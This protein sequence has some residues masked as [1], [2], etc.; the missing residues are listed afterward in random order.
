MPGLNIET[1]VTGA[2]G[3]KGKLTNDELNHIVEVIDSA[4]GDNEGV[5]GL[6]D[7]IGASVGAY[8]MLIPSGTPTGSEMIAKDLKSY[9]LNNNSDA[10]LPELKE[11]MFITVVVKEHLTIGDEGYGKAKL[12][13]ITI[14]GPT[15]KTITSA[16]EYDVLPGDSNLILAD[17]TTNTFT[18]V[19]DTGDA[20]ANLKIDSLSINDGNFTISTQ[21]D[22]LNRDYTVLKTSG[23]FGLILT[24]TPIKVD[25]IVYDPGTYKLVNNV[26]VG[27]L[28][29]TSDKPMLGDASVT[30]SGMKNVTIPA[31]V[32]DNNGMPVGPVSAREITID[33]MTLVFTNKFIYIKDDNGDYI[34]TGDSTSLDY[35]Y[36]GADFVADITTGSEYGTNEL[37]FRGTSLTYLTYT[38]DG[39]ET[40]VAGGTATTTIV[41]PIDKVVSI[42]GIDINY[43]RF[44]GPLTQCHIERNYK[45]TSASYMFS[46]CDQLTNFTANPRTFGN[47]TTLDHAWYQCFIL[48]SFPLIDTSSATNMSW[49]WFAC[50]KLTSF[51]LIDTSNVTDMFSA[52]RQC[53][54]LTSFPLIDTSSA[55]AMSYAWRGCAALTSFPLL[56]TSSVTTMEASWRVCT[57]LTSFPLLDTSSVV[58]VALA[59]R[60]CAALTSFPLLDTGSVINMS[61]AWEGCAALTSF[62]LIDLSSVT[63]LD[64]TWEGCTSL[65]C[66]SGLTRN[67]NAPY[68]AASY[69]FGSTPALVRPNSTEQATI[70]AG[71]NWI[72]PTAC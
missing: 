34:F 3:T 19:T 27:K 12:K 7:A 50:L 25:D 62:P 36:H 9:M 42:R 33:G 46:G 10:F 53:T 61:Y 59:W 57:G 70:V 58:S 22:D 45:Q 66:M 52:W 29:T 38:I 13:T 69:A 1:K 8:A 2:P 39:V 15:N 64:S 6:K 49:A 51:P 11:S 16:I 17:F 4:M 30:T 56:D 32:L 23:G 5:D 55:T 71:D 41:L 21:K 65:I 54:D 48:T 14:P 40:T 44:K 37:Y 35:L 60:G 18:L 28:L 31:T 67:A 72:N 63:T 68:V 20:L 43:M 24:D 47:V 26:I